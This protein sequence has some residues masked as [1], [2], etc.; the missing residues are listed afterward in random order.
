MDYAAAYTK[1]HEDAPKLFAGNSIKVHVQAIAELV[2]MVRPANLLDYGSGKGYQ[3]LAKRVHEEWGGLLPFCYD[4]GVRQL[5]DRPKGPFSGIIC[6]D[7][8]EHIEE[9]DVDAILT[10]IF[11]LVAPGEAFV[12]LAVACRPSK[13][14]LPDGR[15]A[16]LTIKP[17]AW[18]NKK[19][20]RFARPGLI[21][22]AV[23][24]EG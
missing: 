2:R 4:V 19:L 3:Y 5:A 7:V 8:M 17:P 13:K 6:T 16:H 1:M 24:D 21:I 20:E 23:F 15:D 22:K 10:D 11:Q 18:W 9:G 12:Y 14:T